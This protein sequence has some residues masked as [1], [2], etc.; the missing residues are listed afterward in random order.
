LKILFGSFGKHIKINSYMQIV[1]RFRALILFIFVIIVLAA[2]TTRVEVS[3][4]P[5][6]IEISPT[7]IERADATSKITKTAINDVVLF[8][9]T[10]STPSEI[11][12][13][14]THQVTQKPTS[15]LRLSPEDWQSWPIVPTVSEKAKRI[16]ER[17]LA[18]GND[19]EKFSKVG[20][21]QNITTYFLA[22]FDDF[23]RYQLGPDYGYLQEAIDHFSGCYSRKS[24]ATRGGMNVASVLSHY[25][26]DQE[27][28]EKLESPLSCELRLNNP[29]IVLISMEES[30][31]KNNKVENYEKYM[32]QI[33]ETV[34]EEGAVPILATKADNKEGGHQI[35]QSI[36]RLAYDYDIPLWNFWLAVQPLPNQGLLEDGFHLTHGANFYDNP[37]NLKQA[38]PVR[39]LTALQVIDAAWR[40]LN[41]L[42]SPLD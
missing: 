30:W 35:N 28:C 23:D 26:A 18:Q 4:V 34:I 24:V 21:C 40:Q 20:D 29:S 32:R 25:W 11:V 9:T 41:N 15:D 14:P 3:Q 31:G 5:I 22:I 16:Y 6:T 37:N 27:Q 1:I 19:P 8:V 36:A 12:D 10:T 42:S 7:K 13:T 33:I 38:W 39:N 17:G 2:C